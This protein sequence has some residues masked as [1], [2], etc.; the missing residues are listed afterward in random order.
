MVVQA[1]SVRELM[2]KSELKK[3]GEG[4]YADSKGTVYFDINE[5]MTFHIL[6]D[7]AE[8]RAAVWEEVKKQFGADVIKLLED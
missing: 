6:P 7:K 8:A 2:D 4:F 3:I 5:F 1:R